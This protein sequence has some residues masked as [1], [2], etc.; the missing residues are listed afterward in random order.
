MLRK[1]DNI[2]KNWF[3]GLV[4]L[5]PSLLRAEFLETDSIEKV[6]PHVEEGTLVLLGMTDTITDS[7]LS[8]GSKPWRQYLRRQLRPFQDIDEAGNLHDQW[9]YIVALRV[10]VKPIEQEIVQWVDKLQKDEIPVFCL[11][12]RGRNVWYVSVVDQIDNLT[13]FQLKSIGIDFEKTKVP[14]ALKNIDPQLFHCGVFYSDPYDK[15]VFVDKIL[16]QAGY[17]P[18]KVVVIDD[19]WGQLKAIEEKLTEAG[20][21]HLCVLY[22]R[23]EKERRDFNPLVA[24]IQLE[25]LLDNNTVLTEEEAIA[26][27]EMVENTSAD[28]YFKTILRK[29]GHFE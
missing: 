18:K 29:F 15:G 27:A 25:A 2:M 9:T 10:P 22:Q 5:V 20:I 26:K 28:E 17:T 13:N 4:L 16:Q 21:P 6:Y 19:K 12:G 24:A 8:L 1:K 7:S 11:T 3:I 14:E 23:A